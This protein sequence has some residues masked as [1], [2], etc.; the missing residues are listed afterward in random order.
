MHIKFSPL[1]LL[2]WLICIVYPL[3]VH[4]PESRAQSLLG[5]YRD[6]IIVKNHVWGLTKGG[7]IKVYKSDGQEVK[8]A[9]ASGVSAELITNAG[10]DVVVQTGAKI[11]QWSSTDSTWRVIGNLRS[12]AFALVVN[13]KHHV[14]AITDKGVLDVAANKILLPASSPN[15]QLTKFTSLR[16][17]ATC[18]LDSQDNIWLGFGYGEWGG[19]VF[20][21]DTQHHRFIDLK[22]N[23]FQISLHPIKS[24]FQLKASVGA[25]SGLQHMMNSGALAEFN[26]F[27]ARTLYDTWA[28]RDTSIPVPYIGPAVYEPETDLI[29]FYSNLGVFEGKYSADLSRLT[30][31]KKIFEP[32]LHWQ[33]GQP[34]AVGSPMNVLKMLSLGNGKLVLLTQNDGLG[35]WDGK[36]FKL[37]P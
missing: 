24:F 37:I 33:N 12:S 16:K 3:F 27:S 31:W 22:F 7:S 19:N 2:R 32:K 25:S 23:D 5:G 14:F 20:T 11:Q 8:V 10:N 21:Y 15:D 28:A 29:Y 35:L 18:F 34:D 4:S 9:S 36:T 17:P 1:H 30:N 26:N 6:L 13:S